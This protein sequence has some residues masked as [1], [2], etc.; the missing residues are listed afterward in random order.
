MR[1][2][3]TL[4]LVGL[5]SILVNKPLE[6]TPSLEVLFF[7]SPYCRA[8][9]YV[10]EKVLPQI[11]EKYKDKVKII[12]FSTDKKENL[13]A[14]ISLSSFYV[15]GEGAVPAIL[16]GDKFLVGKTFIEKNLPLVIDKFLSQNSF[17]SSSKVMKDIVQEEVAKKKFESFTIPAVIFS[18]LLDGINPCAFAVIVFFISL[19][20]C[21][22]YRRKELIGIGVFYI[23]AIFIAYI[24]IGLGIFNFLYS[25]RFFY[26]FIRIF[27]ILMGSFCVFLSLLCIYDYIKF[28]KTKE[29]QESVLQLPKFL[30]LR[31][32]KL[33]GDEFKG[34]SGRNF[35]ILSLTSFLVGFLVS[36]LEAVCTGQIYLPV[37]S[38]IVRTSNL[39]IKALSYLLLYNL[40]FVVPL[41]VIFILSLWGVSSLQFSNFLRKNFGIIRVAMSLLF[42][43]FAV[44]LF[45]SIL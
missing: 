36:L 41:V 17:P 7:H 2:K 12:Y 15:E 23:L 38:I 11:K 24:L 25:L 20:S 39:R 34:K 9:I 1:L 26:L 28:L 21:Y 32:H 22:G 10:K 35:I 13:D 19:L 3:V 42:F 37:I 40:M 31:I 44:F 30:K 8:C 29:P 18:G 33:M 6:A 43:G 45:W 14:L 16:C 4:F 5:L 27:Y